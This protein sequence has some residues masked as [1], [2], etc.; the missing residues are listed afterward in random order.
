MQILT[1]GKFASVDHRGMPSKDPD[2]ERLTLAAFYS[3]DDDR[4]V[5]PLQELLDE[6]HP[7]LYSA[8]TFKE[9][10]AKF[11]ARGLDGKKVIESM[12]IEHE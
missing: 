11:T 9:Y 5:A 12:H 8:C 3:A 10:M 7:P 1:N 6:S 2:Q 4:V